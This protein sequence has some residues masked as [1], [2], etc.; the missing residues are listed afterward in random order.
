MH[1]YVFGLAE[2][3]KIGKRKLNR[4]FNQTTHLQLVVSKASLGH[5]FPV[6][7]LGHFAVRPEMR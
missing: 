1:R 4:I 3:G 5:L 6:T 2:L 7:L